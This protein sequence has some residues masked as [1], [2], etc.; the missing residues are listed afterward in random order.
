MVQELVSRGLFLDAADDCGWTP[1]H[2]ASCIGRADVAWCLLS[3]GANALRRNTRGLTPVELCS[4]GGTKELI[5]GF[6]EPGRPRPAS[7]G[8]RP[9]FV[10][11]SSVG[12][13][14]EA[15]DQ[16]LRFE[17]CFVPRDPALPEGRP[18][19][20]REGPE[21]LK[22]LALDIFN[23]G[24]GHGVAFLVAAGVVRDYPV[25]I[26]HFLTSRKA[27]PRRFGEFLGEAFPLAQNLRLE[28]LNSM[29][30]L[31]T[32]VISALEAIFRDVGVPADFLRCNR[33]VQ[34]V[35][36]FWWLQHEEERRARCE[37]GIGPS[38]A[39]LP[40]AA[41]G[42]AGA[43]AGEAVGFELMRSVQRD[44][45]LHGLMFSALM[46]RRWLHGGKRMTLTE[47]VALNEGIEVGV[48][49]VPLKVQEPLYQAVSAGLDFASDRLGTIRP[50]LSPAAEGRAMI[51]FNGRAQVSHNGI[52]SDFPELRP[53]LLAMRGGVSS[54]GMS[55]CAMEEPLSRCSRD[56]CSDGQSSEERAW[57]TLQRWYL[58]FAPV[59]AADTKHGE[60]PPPYAFVHLKR[61]AL[62]VVDVPQ[63]RLVLTSRI[64]D[65]KADQGPLGS[66]NCEDWL[67]LC[68]LLADGRFQPME[69]P[70][71]QLRFDDAAEFEA[72]AA[73]LAEATSERQVAAAFA[74]AA[75]PTG[76][77]PGAS[78]QGAACTS[79]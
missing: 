12:V 76:P 1:L 24:A 77:L 7:A 40:P 59:A 58:F 61:I 42:G 31:G 70:N 68:L 36:H 47:W 56:D 28:I 45:T 14:S 29:P 30:L 44:R 11:G 2:V 39:A 10:G 63:R 69:A 57:L 49:D 19:G 50:S 5:A 18:A 53:R 60:R 71:L 33:L 79:L 3:A 16:G 25:E 43:A 38:G 46:L 52:P 48:L 64:S 32:G 13:S 66:A 75:A 65:A 51:L 23:R 78:R 41:V 9:F 6:A 67:E 74:P 26:N 37:D 15:Q 54:A 20:Q 72:W 73:A 62:R 4:H 22:Q 27:C 8:P 34:G 55:S 35:A 17:P 21:G